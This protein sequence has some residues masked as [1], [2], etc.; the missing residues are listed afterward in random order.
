MS[1]RSFPRAC[2]TRITLEFTPFFNQW[3]ISLTAL[4]DHSTLWPL[5]LKQTVAQP[6]FTSSAPFWISGRQFHKQTSGWE[7]DGTEEKCEEETITPG[8]PLVWM[9]GWRR[10]LKSSF[11]LKNTMKCVF[12]CVLFFFR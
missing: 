2:D 8:M 3:G 12:S 7:P 5:V 10:H 4:F 6:G 9:L 11:N 1:S